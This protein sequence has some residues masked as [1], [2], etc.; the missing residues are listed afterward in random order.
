MKLSSRILTTS[1]LLTHS[2]QIL[3]RKQILKTQLCS[4]K[5]NKL[6]YHK[7]Q[8]LIFQTT[9]KKSR[10]LDAGSLLKKKSWRKRGSS[11]KQRHTQQMNTLGNS[12]R[13]LQPQHSNQGQI[14]RREALQIGRK[15]IRIEKRGTKLRRCI[16]LWA[17]LYSLQSPFLMLSL[18]SKCQVNETLPPNEEAPSSIKRQ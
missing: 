11:V 15:R 8:M 5:S 12:S 17:E 1:R 10:N 13:I 3:A 6:L 4:L 9:S 18:L 2:K 14:L 16:H 7:L